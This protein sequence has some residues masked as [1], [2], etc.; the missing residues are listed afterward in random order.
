MKLEEIRCE[1]ITTEEYREAFREMLKSDYYA[2]TKW[3]LEALKAL[4]DI[5]LNHLD[6]ACV[7]QG[8]ML[9]F[10]VYLEEFAEKVWDKGF[11]EGVWAKEEACWVIKEVARHSVFKIRRPCKVDASSLD[12]VE[13]LVSVFILNVWQVATVGITPHVIKVT[14]NQDDINSC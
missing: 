1:P 6:I 12:Y 11:F 7:R 3:E 5:A 2:F 4:I 8:L 13:T 9:S 10:K 14:F